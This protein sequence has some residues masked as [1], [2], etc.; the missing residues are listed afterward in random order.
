MKVLKSLKLSHE[1]ICVVS[2]TNEIKDYCVKNDI[3]F[4]YSNKQKWEYSFDVNHDLIVSCMFNKILSEELLKKPKFGGINIHQSLLPLYR[5]KSPVIAAVNNLEEY[6]GFTIHYM[7]SGVDTGNIIFQNKWPIDYELT[8][9]DLM[10]QFIGLIPVGLQFAIKQVENNVKG[11][12]QIDNQSTYCQEL[13]RNIDWYTPLK[14]LV[15]TKE[16][17]I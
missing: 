2:D 7:D 17:Y 12:I 8:L 6:I 14:D 3:P 4:V 11:I 5:G 1:I 10:N 9:E 16:E 13:N 15:N